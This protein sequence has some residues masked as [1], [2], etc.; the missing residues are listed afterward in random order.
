MDVDRV[1]MCAYKYGITV[2]DGDSSRLHVPNKYGRY[3]PGTRLASSLGNF[4][5]A[6]YIYTAAYVFHPSN[7]IPVF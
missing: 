5:L 7:S 6:R 2:E 3:L 4:D 1:D